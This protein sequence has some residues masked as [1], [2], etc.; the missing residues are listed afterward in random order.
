MDGDSDVVTID[1]GLERGEPESY[2]NRRTTIPAWFPTVLIAVF[3]LLSTTASG[4]PPHAAINQVFSLRVGPADTYALTDHG[5][6]LAQTFGTLGSFD[7]ETGLMVWQ[8]GQ[9]TPAYRLR[10]G[11]GLVLMRPW[12]VGGRDPGTTAISAISGMPRWER[13][14]TV[15][16]VAGSSALL[17][18][19]ALRSL[20][21]T[22]RRVQGPAIEAIDPFT[23]N[24]RWSVPVRSTAVMMGLPG[25]ADEGGRLLLVHDDRTLAVHDMA[26][27]ERMAATTVPAA[28]Y[29]PGNP[30]VAGGKILLRHPGVRNTEITAYDS[31]TL[32][33]LWTVPAGQAYKI[34]ACGEL[35][36]LIGAMGVRAVDPATGDE[37]WSRPQWRD[38]DVRGTM[39]VA[40]GGAEGTD[41]VAIIDPATGADRVAIA[42]WRPVGGA[43]GGD[44]LLLTRTM[45]GGGRTM[46][47]V[48]RPDQPQPR[49][50]ANL[51]EG[52][53]DCQSVPG[54]LVCRSMY[55]ELVV[56]AYSLKGAN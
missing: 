47:A 9:S 27:G 7:L 56:W 18:V 5:Q 46:V 49:V 21:G 4:P 28:D 42:G 20:S 25:P 43:G 2:A 19:N 34:K 3:V 55:G 29:D 12:T 33:Q 44:H 17:A 36:C 37:V 45:E 16:T 52:T 6:L 38:I 41:P 26:T 24:A 30:A 50:L 22:G 54:R 13:P 53:G 14:G 51:P 31:A 23:G 39:Y 10:L 32:K 8:A 15:V 40:F 48:A 1:L 11:D 35:A